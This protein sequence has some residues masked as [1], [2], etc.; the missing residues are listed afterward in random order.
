MYFVELLNIYVPDNTDSECMSHY[1]NDG[2]F[3]EV[4]RIILHH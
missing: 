3:T 2:L 4:F 1:N